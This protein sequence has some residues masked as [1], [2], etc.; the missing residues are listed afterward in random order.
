[1]RIVKK[2]TA[3]ND[4][5][6]LID[7]E[8][9]VTSFDA[10]FGHTLVLDV[11]IE[12]NPILGPDAMCWLS[13]DKEC[14]DIINF[15]DGSNITKFPIL[16]TLLGFPMPSE[17]GGL[18]T[19]IM[20]FS[21][22]TIESMAEF[23][24]AAMLQ[25]PDPT[26][27][28]IAIQSNGER[29]LPGAD[30]TT[31]LAGDASGIY[32]RFAA[33]R[34]PR[35]GEA[36]RLKWDL[37]EFVENNGVRRGQ[38]IVTPT[39][40]THCKTIWIRVNER[41]EPIA[42]RLRREKSFQLAPGT[43]Y[44]L[45]DYIRDTE[46]ESVST[47]LQLVRDYAGQRGAGRDILLGPM[48][49]DTDSADQKTLN[50]LRK[51][52]ASFLI[53]GAP[54][55]TATVI[56]R[57]KDFYENRGN[58]LSFDFLSR[59]NFGE[60]TSLS[61]PPERLLRGS[62]SMWWQGISLKGVS[63]LQS[64]SVFP[65][66]KNRVKRELSR[67]NDPDDTFGDA[68]LLLELVGTRIR[69]LSSGAT[70]IVEAVDQL[71][72]GSTL[73]TNLT[74]TDVAGKFAVNELVYPI[75]GLDLSG[76]QG[77][78]ALHSNYFMFV[79]S[80]VT[81]LE[82]VQFGF[83]VPV[84]AS[85]IFSP[86]NGARAIVSK[87]DENGHAIAFQILDSGWNAQETGSTAA[88]TFIIGSETVAGYEHNAALGVYPLGT[89]PLGGTYNFVANVNAEITV[90]FETKVTYDS[91]WSTYGYWTEGGGFLS[92]SYFCTGDNYY[93]QV[94]SYETVSR[95]QEI[96]LKPVLK[97]HLHPLGFQAFHVLDQK[98]SVVSAAV[99]ANC[100]YAINELGQ[101]GAYVGQDYDVDELDVYADGARVPSDGYVRFGEGIRTNVI[102]KDPPDHRY[103]I[104]IS[105]KESR[106]RPA[107]NPP[108]NVLEPVD[109]LTI[110]SAPTQDK[111]KGV[112]LWGVKVGEYMKSQMSGLDDYWFVFVTGGSADNNR[113]SCR[114]G[115]EIVDGAGIVATVVAGWTDVAKNIVY[116]VLAFATEQD[117]LDFEFLTAQ[118][119]V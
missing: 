22:A 1:M 37:P 116:A 51:E 47:L 93:F 75:S 43:I 88:I 50:N 76:R 62:D 15:A 13:C 106:R 77:K 21:Q 19:T 31:E 82:Q 30:F 90:S 35:T 104:V 29:Y 24:I 14:L 65:S 78:A 33:S 98:N 58:P 91:Q 55:D 16:S 40:D 71:T 7:G 28:Q 81:S 96:E 101:A 102:L 52:L 99:D 109:P 46:G 60:Q 110:V 84:G 68:S 56:K 105:L 54:A 49:R 70:A 39:A 59:A 94:Y 10:Y 3:R 42:I 95:V 97:R 86:D 53:D 9:G 25:D 36:I 72:Y 17:V 79:G 45:P 8:A 64:F 114:P 73:V 57:A 108:S 67:S 74:L 41:H 26:L 6:I 117:A 112:A 34:F 63:V 113:R 61:Y 87:V 107:V 119:R 5:E 103:E 66:H 2:L 18:G 92:D 80:Q 85:V 111:S 44:S 118:R 100:Y 12:D 23:E 20:D 115:T 48:I 32:V 27:P 69:G 83:P 11:D 89:T 38:I 4:G